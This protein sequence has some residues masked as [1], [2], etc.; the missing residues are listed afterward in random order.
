MHNGY[1]LQMLFVQL[2]KDVVLPGYLVGM[3][4][5]IFAEAILFL[6]INLKECYGMTFL[7][8]GLL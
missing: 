7:V 2:I 3:V 6:P 1:I 5:L 8:G 4:W